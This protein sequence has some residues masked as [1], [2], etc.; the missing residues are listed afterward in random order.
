MKQKL[1]LV[2]LL[3]FSMMLFGTMGCEP[4]DLGD[5]PEYIDFDEMTDERDNQTYKTIQIGTQ[6]WMAENLNYETDNSWCYDNDPGNCNTYGRLY[7]WDTARKACPDG[8]HLPS[9]AEWTTLTDF[10]GGINVAGGKMKSTSNLWDAPNTDATNESGWSG[11]PGGY[12][13]YVAGFSLLGRYGSWWSSSEGNAGHAWSLTL[14]YYYGLVY[15][16]DFVKEFGFSVRC[17]RD[18]N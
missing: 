11:L 17:L 5:P 12:R 13:H 10:L 4:D 14:G 18:D 15:R 2:L 9:D 16:N 7:D 8:W 6:T 3:V 1:L